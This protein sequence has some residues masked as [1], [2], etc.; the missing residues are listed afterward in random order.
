MTNW[1]STVCRIV[2]RCRRV[3][4]VRKI[5]GAMSKDLYSEICVNFGIDSVLAFSALTSLVGRQE[6][7]P[8]CK[9]LE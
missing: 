6:G 8:A 7:H 5:F 2:E 4:I 3:K 1:L 9:K